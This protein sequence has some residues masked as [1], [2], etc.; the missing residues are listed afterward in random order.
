MGRLLGFASAIIL[1]SAISILPAAV[2]SPSITSGLTISLD[3]A[4]NSSF[5][6]T[7]W[8]A[9]DGTTPNAT[10]QSVGQYDSANHWVTFNDSIA[11]IYATF[12]NG[13]SGDSINPT[14]DMTVE[15]WVKFNTVNTSGWNIVAT[16]WFNGSG[17]SDFHFGLHLGH[18][19]LFLTGAGAQDITNLS[20]TATNGSWHQLAFTVVNP[21][22][23]NGSSATTSGTAVV[24]WDGVAVATATGT[25]VYH[26][27]NP[28]HYLDL[29]DRR[30][31]GNL[32]ITGVLT[33]FRMYNRSLSAAEINQNYRWGA[34]DYSLAAGPYNTVSPSITGSQIVT[35]SETSTTGT[36]LNTPTSYTYQ[37]SRSATSNGTYTDIAGA[38]GQ[39]YQTV[40]GDVG[41]YLKATVSATN[42]SGTFTATSAATSVI[43]SPSVVLTFTPASSLPVYRTVNNLTAS[44]GTVAGKVTFSIKGKAIP[45][46]KG[47]V[48]NAGNSYT[49]VCPWRPATHSAVSIVATFTPTDAGYNGTVGSIS[50]VP[51]KA[52]T[53]NR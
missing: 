53:N 18:P 35:T 15:T 49:A 13:S 6:G 28:S 43:I 26:T 8:L 12:G 51:A 22:N 4:S 40:S 27:N 17:S 44:T 19:D 16:R 5:S 24:Y 30:A 10:L 33:K 38:T 11:P 48:V 37:W 36:W 23:M 52:R 20:Y 1:I 34:S 31:T 41:Y 14:G 47:K 32:G 50:L 45:G 29:G 46:C 9:Q 21:N 3:S 2:A 7:T 39:T 42:S 25:T